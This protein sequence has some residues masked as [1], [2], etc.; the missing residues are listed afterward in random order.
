M[1]RD[2]RIAITGGAGFIGTKLCAALLDRNRVTVLDSL[3]RDSLKSSGLV[4]HPNLTLIRGDVR[5]RAAVD[6]AL[7][8]ATMIVHLASVAGVDTVLT[9]PVLTMEVSLKGTMNALE[10]ALQL[11][12]VKRFIDFSTSEVFGRYAWRVAEGDVTSL[13]AVGEARWTYAVSK[14]ATE[15]LAYN[16]FKQYGLPALSV[17]PFN[18]YGPG[19]V[20]EGAIHHFVV[21]A[22]KNETLEIHNEGDQIRAWCYIDDLVDAVLLCL[23]HDEAVG[24]TFNIGNPRSAITVF[25]LAL[26]VKRLSGAASPVVHVERKSQDIELRV[27]DIR[28]AQKLLGFRPRVDLEEGLIKTIDWYR[29]N[30]AGENVRPPN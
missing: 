3:R 12:G 28:K 29:R 9:N 1:I 13:G 8:G 11:K 4:G 14:L 23:E 10:S 25:N 15:H 5:D 27:P 16:M 24:H 20:G 17:R 22:L 26:L 18:I 7:S 30:P 21:R 19:Q 6:Q 2:E